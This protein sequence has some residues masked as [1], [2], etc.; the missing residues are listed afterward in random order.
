MLNTE[1]PHINEDNIVAFSKKQPR[2]LAALG[3]LT[4]VPLRLNAKVCT[5]YIT[6]TNNLNLA[7]KFTHMATSNFYH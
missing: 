4:L 1:L 2:A 3:S 5:K 6:V 7:T